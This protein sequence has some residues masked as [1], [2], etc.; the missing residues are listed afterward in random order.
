MKEI[1]NK[2]LFI[3]LLKRYLLIFFGIGVALFIF[4]LFSETFFLKSG[5]PYNEY[6]I[7]VL[8]IIMWIALVLFSFKMIIKDVS[9]KYSMK[10]DVKQY[11]LIISKVVRYTF[12]TYF[13]IYLFLRIF[14]FTHATYVRSESEIPEFINTTLF[15]FA[16]RFITMLAETVLFKDL[17]FNTINK[18]SN[19]MAIIKLV[20]FIIIRTLILIV[21]TS[22]LTNRI[23]F[24]FRLF[25]GN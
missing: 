17:I 13:L 16:F 23:D 5:I 8:T 6:V 25:I 12:Y 11:Q 22:I 3:Q 14:N 10:G 24:Y 21:L 1:T 9:T 7:D 18:K 4:E 15:V 19:K 2:E 20:L